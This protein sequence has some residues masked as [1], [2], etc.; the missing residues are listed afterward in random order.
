MSAMIGWWNS[1]NE[2]NGDEF[3]NN[4]P[5]KA[6]TIAINRNSIDFINFECFTNQK[7]RLFS[8]EY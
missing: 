1:F 2:N 7:N 5:E 4:Q 3:N 8:T 6:L